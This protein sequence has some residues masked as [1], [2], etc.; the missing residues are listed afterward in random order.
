[1]T[2]F[3]FVTLFATSYP[4]CATLAFLNN[5]VEIRVDAIKL[6]GADPSSWLHFMVHHQ[7]PEPHV[8]EDIGPWLRILQITTNLAVA[9]NCG[10]VFFTSEFSVHLELYWKVTIIVV[11]VVI[12][13]IILITII[14][15]CPARWRASSSLSMH[16]C[17]SVS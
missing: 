1:M 4:L 12:T 3:G 2:Q 7:R 6:V 14:M 9:T 17:S 15:C 8:V 16:S 5:L 10:L 11:V 13:I